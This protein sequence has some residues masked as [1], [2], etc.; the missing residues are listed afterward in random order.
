MSALLKIRLLFTNCPIFN[1]SLLMFLLSH[2]WDNELFI[3][4]SSLQTLL[5]MSLLKWLNGKAPDVQ[6]PWRAPAAG[7][8]RGAGTA[9]CLPSRWAWNHTVLHAWLFLRPLQ[10]KNTTLLLSSSKAAECSWSVHS[11]NPSP[12]HSSII[13]KKGWKMTSHNQCYSIKPST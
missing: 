6:L 1:N 4:G 9:F 5:S 13:S 2:K 10:S 3:S 7:G 12:F 11:W 8:W